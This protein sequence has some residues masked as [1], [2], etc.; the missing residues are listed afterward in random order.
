V[1]VRRTT[2]AAAREV[3]VEAPVAAAT[4]RR[5]A[6]RSLSTR[7]PLLSKDARAEVLQALRCTAHHESV[8]AER[9]LQACQ[10]ERP[11]NAVGLPVPITAPALAAM[12]AQVVA[13]GE[14]K[15]AKRPFM[16]RHSSV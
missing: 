3:K 5:G 8:V 11:D 9:L 12:A 16:T 14:L 7:T 4:R 2:L 10:A 15:P 13:Q 1:P 6:S